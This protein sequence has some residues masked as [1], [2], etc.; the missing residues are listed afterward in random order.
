MTQVNPPY[1][2]TKIRPTK[3][4]DLDLDYYF[5]SLERIMQQLYLRTGG[6]A[7]NTSSGIGEAIG[8][9]GLSTA[10]KFKPVDPVFFSISSAHTTSGNEFIRATAAATVTLRTSPDDREEVTVFVAGYFNVTIS[11]SDTISGESTFLIS[12]NTKVVTFEYF[13][14]IGEWVARSMFEQTIDNRKIVRSAADLADVDSSVLYLVDGQI[15]MGSQ[16]VSI[17]SGGI[18]IMGLGIGVSKLFSSENSYNMFTGSATGN[19]FIDSLSLT[20]SGTSSSLFSVTANTG[21]EDISLRNVNFI[22]STSVGEFTAFGSM[23]CENIALFFCDDGFTFTGAWSSGAKITDMLVRFMGTSS[24]IFKAGTGLTF[25]SIFATDLNADLPAGTSSVADFS[26]SNFDSDNLF[27]MSE[28]RVTRAGVSDTTDANYFPNIT[29]DD[30]QSRW[31]GN[32]GIRNTHVGSTWKLTT[33]AATTISVTST[34][35]K[36]AGTTT[37]S[38]EVHFD[39]ATDNAA[40][41]S[42]AD[43]ITCSVFSSVTIEGGSGDDVEVMIRVYDVSA[44][45]YVDYFSVQ[46]GI[47]GSSGQASYTLIDTVDLALDDR[48]E[49]WVS[50]NTDTTDVTMLEGSVLTISKI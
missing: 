4:I 19:I 45:A 42:G 23:F 40:L 16:E 2:L 28:S 36:I 39:S 27:Q 24:T 7:G 44:A 15:D 38:N 17:P 3:D 37:Y 1:S 50:N 49:L 18:S 34:F 29:A 31:S 6:A 13:S 33:T 20:A 43:L 5:A 22:S 9:M 21:G 25:A 35:Y 32:S 11:S 10:D 12:K 14:D 30:E 47:P 48:V 46:R 8:M 41:H 26:P